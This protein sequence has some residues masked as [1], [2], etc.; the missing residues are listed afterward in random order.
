[1]RFQNGL[2]EQS[3]KTNRQTMSMRYV[4]GAGGFE[5]P[6]GGI[7]IRCLTA[8]LRPNIT[9]W[10]GRYRREQFR[11]TAISL[12]VLN[13]SLGSE[14]LATGSDCTPDD[15]RPIF[16]IW[17]AKGPPRPLIHWASEMILRT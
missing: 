11:S 4:A 6:H 17:Q 5:P 14:T 13:A 2:A 15:P 12:G 8:W 3:Q 1:M 16:S 10:A 9:N 7:K